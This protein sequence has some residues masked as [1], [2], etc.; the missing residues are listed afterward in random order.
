MPKRRLP[1]I[2]VESSEETRPRFIV[3]LDR[4]IESGRPALLK[5]ERD[6]MSLYQNARRK[7]LTLWK[8]RIGKSKWVMKIR[9]S[10][11]EEDPLGAYGDAYQC[12]LKYGTW[13][14]LVAQLQQF[15]S[16]LVDTEQTA[17]RLRIHYRRYSD[18]ETPIS[19][20]AVGT[21]FQVSI[22][23]DEEPLWDGEVDTRKHAEGVAPNAPL[24][25]K[26][27][28]SASPGRSSSSSSVGA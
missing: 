1:P 5:S 13:K 26:P 25:A 11:T 19:I 3:I 10:D 21:K 23:E 14:D 22:P 15:R 6:C 9:L 27:R 24:N 17:K 16:I 20:E 8:R 18:K 4:M 7:D 12:R 2:K 28:R